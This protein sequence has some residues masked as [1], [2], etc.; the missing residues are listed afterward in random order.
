MNLQSKFHLAGHH[1]VEHDDLRDGKGGSVRPDM[2]L[3]FVS[4][5]YLLALLHCAVL[6]IRHIR[7]ESARAK[8]LDRRC[9]D[10]LSAFKHDHPA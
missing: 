9:A 10:F 3:Y 4:G 6:F 7:A 5:A 8:A 2:F 1:A